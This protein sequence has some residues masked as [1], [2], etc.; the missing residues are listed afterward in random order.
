MHLVRLGV[1]RAPKAHGRRSKVWLWT[2]WARCRKRNAY[3]LVIVDRFS[4]LYR[5]LPMRSAKA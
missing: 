5:F 4:K 1:D 3:I 2:S